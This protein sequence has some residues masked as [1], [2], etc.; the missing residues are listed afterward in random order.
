[1]SG[2]APEPPTAAPTEDALWVS[3]GLPFGNYVLLRRV[4]LGGTAEIF[5]ARRLG[6]A[7]TG[8]RVALKRLLPH[9]AEDPAFV[10]MFDNEARLLSLLDH[11]GIARV[12][13]L[14]AVGASPY[15]VMAYIDGCDL[16]IALRALRA[17]GRR[18]SAAAVAAIGWQAADALAYA[19]AFVDQAGVPLRIVHRDVSPHNL[20]IEATGR[21]RL[22]DFGIAKYVG[23]EGATA[24][25]VVKGKHA[26]MSPEQVRRE[27]LDGR[28]DVFSLGAVL[29]ELASGRRL[30]QG[31]SPLDTLALVE[32]A[33]V[34]PLG[35][36]AP[37]I[38]AAVAGPI[39]AALSRRP[40][41]RPSAAELAD[42][43][44]AFG[45]HS[46]AAD[47]LEEVARLGRLARGTA[48]GAESRSLGAYREAL[49]AAELGVD[50]ALLRRGGSDITQLP[51]GADLAGR[52]AERSRSGL[53]AE[54]PPPSPG[55]PAARPAHPGVT[56]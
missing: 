18:A 52:L 10:Q 33:V 6:A 32:A 7:D 38:P 37:E 4:S 47:L 34:P 11:P 3:E 31:E 15:L 23:G 2:A 16:A 28:S 17:Q 53:G 44:R 20:M 54:P 19:H 5:V 45:A 51:G 13:E 9:A 56:S 29:Y 40:G 8:E 43:L 42:A 22:I 12:H 27:P 46:G 14:G 30:F 26:F 49:R 25:G 48:E 50:E 39:A 36:V 55:A 35:L 21:V 24:A 41:E 1:M